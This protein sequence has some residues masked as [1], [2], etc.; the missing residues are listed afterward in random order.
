[1]RTKSSKLLEDREKDGNSLGVEK[2]L[3]VNPGH[4]LSYSLLMLSFFNNIMSSK[5]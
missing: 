4:L 2:E 5:L 3:L 1:M